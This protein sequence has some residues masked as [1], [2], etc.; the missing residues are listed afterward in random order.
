M[1]LV[2]ALGLCFGVSLLAARMGYSVALGAFLIGAIIA[3]TREAGRISVLVE[4]VRDMFAAI[5]FVAVG[6]LIDPRILWDYAGPIAI[7]TVICVV[8]KVVACSAGTF[9]A[10]H[11]PKTSLRVGMAIAQIGEFSFIIA[12]LGADIKATGPYLYPVTVAVSAVTTLLTP[13][14]IRSSDPAVHWFERVAPPTWMHSLNLYGQ[15]FNQSNRQARASDQ[16]R[17]LLRKWTLQ[18]TLNMTLV[19]G[20]FLAAA[21]LGQRLA[22]AGAESSPPSSRYHS[23]KP[24][25]V[26]VVAALVA[27]PLLIASV[28]KLRAAAMVL[29]EMSVAKSA[30]GAQ[31]ATV[32]RVITNTIVFA[33]CG[34]MLLWILTLSAAILPPWYILIGLIAGVAGVAALLWQSFVKLYAKAQIAIHETLATVHEQAQAEA[35]AP[36]PMPPLLREAVLRTILV[37]PGAAADGKLIRELALRT[38]TG[39]SVVGIER[40]GTPIVNPGPDE[41]IKAGDR[42]LLIGTEGQLAGATPLLE[43][44]AP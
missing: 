41:E 36:P 25:I 15:W 37:A 6:M 1:M 14:L 16:I 43:S 28:R 40:E 44:P 7:I 39:A 38:Q 30:A 29:A 4:P 2:A 18:I 34:G 27:L 26:W 13:Y 17:K 22:P 10:G 9:L 24:T 19:S 5:F 12:K 23:T 35:E 8:G 32:R 31:T 3:E 21:W 11:D 33:G 20:V 42:V